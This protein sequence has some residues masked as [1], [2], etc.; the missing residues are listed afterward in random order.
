MLGRR[1]KVKSLTCAGAAISVTNL[2]LS[3]GLSGR[4]GGAEGVRGRGS[5][6]KVLMKTKNG[7]GRNRER[8]DAIMRYIGRAVVT[9]FIRKVRW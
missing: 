1:K 2:A 3:I 9:F 5:E 8:F 4:E 6:D 7:G